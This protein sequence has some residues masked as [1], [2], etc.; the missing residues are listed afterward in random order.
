MNMRK[1]LVGRQ[2]QV[3]TGRKEIKKKGKV[4]IIRMFL[5]MYYNVTN[6]V[7]F[8]KRER[9]KLFHEN[10]IQIILIYDKIDSKLKPVKN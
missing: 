5:Y 2:K 3:N 9:I 7:I 4:R 10:D 6:L 8:K 1:V